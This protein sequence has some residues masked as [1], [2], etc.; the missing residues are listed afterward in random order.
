VLRRP[1]PPG[2]FQFIAGFSLKVD[3]GEI[4][5][6][7]PLPLG[8][9]ESGIEIK[10]D[11]TNMQVDLGGVRNF[12][13]EEASDE[14]GKFYVVSPITILPGKSMVFEL[15]DLPREPAWRRWSKVIMGCVVLFLVLITTLFALWRPRLDT[16]PAARFEAL[17][18]ELSALEASGAPPEQRARLLAELEAL[19]RQAGP[20]A[21]WDAPSDGPG[22]SR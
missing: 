12:S 1:I 13:A 5:W 22:P 4:H 9:F 21:G 19:Y 7:M 17:L 8:A 14:R 16:A 10:R 15:H 2:G 3:D 20:Q 18:D 11:G 6:D